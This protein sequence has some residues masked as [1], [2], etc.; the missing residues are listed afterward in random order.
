MDLEATVEGTT[1]GGYDRWRGRGNSHVMAATCAGYRDGH[2]L[3]CGPPGRPVEG[4]EKKK[5]VRQ[6]TRDVSGATAEVGTSQAPK[7]A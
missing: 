6:R 3:T 5:T 7:C 1:G 4:M 2:R